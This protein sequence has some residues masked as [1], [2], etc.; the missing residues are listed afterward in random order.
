MA[1][2]AREITAG[3]ANDYERAVKLQ[4][5]FALDGGFTYDTEVQVGSGSQAIARFLRDKEGF[6]VHFS[7]AMA[8]MARTL[9]IP[10][11]V[12]VGFTPGTPQADGTMSVGLR[13]AH[14]WPELYF[15]GVGWTRF[16]PTPNRGTV[17]DYTRTDTPGTALP[18]PDLPSQLFVHGARRPRRRRSESCTAAEK[19]LERPCGSGPRRR[20][21]EPRTT[22][23]PWF[24]IL[25]LTL[26]GLAALA[27]PL[28][29]LLW[30]MRARAVRLGSHGRT[31]ADAAAA[32]AGG[33]AGGDRYGVGLRH[34]AGR[35]ADAPQGGGADRPRRASRPDGGG[36]RPPGRRRGGAGPVRARPR[37]TAGLADDVRRHVAGLRATVGRGARLRA[38][39][40]PRSAVRVAWAA[41]GGL[42]LAE[43]PG[44][45]ALD[46]GRCARPSGQAAAEAVRR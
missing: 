4:D 37:P 30:R 34:R 27:V 38:L 28:L 24:L 20:R 17:P 13:D 6:C 7:F 40:A 1:E 35:F 21:S 29:P 26:A 19:K 44:N 42:D 10:A 16:E 11:R 15:E 46:G 3:S 39:L 2:T 45:G 41:S 31:E 8:A 18:D 43:V 9:G 25:G 33:L 32:D 14:A 23:P 12:A 22:G 36:L 5:W